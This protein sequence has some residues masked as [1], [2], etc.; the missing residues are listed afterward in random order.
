[1]NIS[2]LVVSQIQCELYNP[3]NEDITDKDQIKSSINFS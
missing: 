3:E 1:M 2:I